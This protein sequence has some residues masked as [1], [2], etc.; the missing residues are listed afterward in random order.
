VRLLL[1]PFLPFLPCS[2]PS[3]SCSRA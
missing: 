2:R 1:L 3:C